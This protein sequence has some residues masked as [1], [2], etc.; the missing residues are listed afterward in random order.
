MSAP[1]FL[2]LGGLGE[3]CL[4]CS[5]RGWQ[6]RQ[7]EDHN[8]VYLQH[9]R[10]ASMTERNGAMNEVSAA[11]FAEA[12]KLDN[13]RWS[14]AYLLGKTRNP[15]DFSSSATPWGYSPINIQSL[16]PHPSETLFQAS[17]RPSC[18]PCN[19]LPSERAIMSFVATLPVAL[20]EVTTDGCHCR[21]VCEKPF[22]HASLSLSSRIGWLGSPRASGLLGTPARPPS[23]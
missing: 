21:F 6:R 23:P 5:K 18:A 19:A 16:V 1:I 7:N 9:R 8:K 14:E 4:K 17:L 10:D 22:A 3:V 13:G 11:P 12:S 20:V 15:L 2:A